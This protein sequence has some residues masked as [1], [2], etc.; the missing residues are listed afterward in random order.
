MKLLEALAKTGQKVL[1]LGLICLLAQNSRAQTT[2]PQHDELLNGLRILLWS[3]PG[4]QNVTLK[5][6]IHSGAAFDTKGKA[7]TMALLGDLLFPDAA[8]REY[9][10][11]EMGGRLDVETDYDS[12]SITLQGRASDYDRI[13]DVLRSAVVTT[14]LTPE[15]LTKARE[16][17]IKKLSEAKASPSEIADQAIASRLLGGDFPYTRPV[18]GTA[19][20]LKQIER[21]DLL[22]ARDRFLT[23]NNATLAIT[24]GV[25]QRRA[26]R[27]LRQLLGGWR[28]GDQVVP[29]TFRQP[30]PPDGRILIVPSS[31]LPLAELRVG[32][33]GVARSDPDFF[34]VSMLTVLARDRWQKLA[35]APTGSTF[36]ARADAHTL[37]EIFVMGSSVDGASATRTLETAYAVIKSLTSSP[38]SANEL[39]MVKGFSFGLANQTADALANAWLDIDTFGLKPIDEQLKQRTSISAAD[40]Q[41]VAGRLFGSK[42]IATVIVGDTAQ[43]KAEFAPD[44]VQL[45]ARR[46]NHSTLNQWSLP[47]GTYH[48]LTRLTYEPPLMKGRSAAWYTLQTNYKCFAIPLQP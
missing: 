29:S 9:F 48:S 16:A 13:V 7:G 35:G 25:D 28:K 30:D 3:R 45:L 42:V 40:L 17:R 15:N 6:R 19:G 23:P 21:A 26:M 43:L 47:G 4:D 11:G 44:G 27:A 32:T 24:G 36:F 8:T 5:L 10:T 34:A 22:L 31:G 2:E 38:A 1:I 46:T 20:S 33:R 14:Q 39:E 18:A 37:P 41:R 12:I